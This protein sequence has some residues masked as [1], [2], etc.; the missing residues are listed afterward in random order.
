MRGTTLYQNTLR[1]VALAPLDALEGLLY[2]VSDALLVVAAVA[3]LVRLGRLRG[4]ER[5]QTKWFA[6]GGSH[7]WRSTWPGRS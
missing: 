7:G 3:L 2:V 1:R 6:F 5:Q 4:A